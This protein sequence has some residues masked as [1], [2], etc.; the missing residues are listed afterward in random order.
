[1]ATYG[2]VCSHFSFLS[3][4]ISHYTQRTMKRH[5]HLDLIGWLHRIGLLPQRLTRR[6]ASEDLLKALYEAHSEGS[7]APTSLPNLGLSQGAT[8][9]LQTELRG[10]GYLCPNSL[11]LT[12][13]GK[14]RAIELTRAHRLYELYLAEHSGYSPEDWHRLAH[15]KEHELTEEEHERIAKLLGNPL[16]DPHGDPIPTSE[17]IRPDVPLALPLEELAPH[18]WYFVLHIEDDEPVSY[19]RLSAL[20]LTRDSIF[21]LEE[22]TPTSCTIRYEGETFTFPT[23]MLLAL[24]LR[25]ASEKEVTETH[26]DQVQRLTRLPLGTETKVLALS[27]ACRGAMR[28]RLMD[29][30]FVPGS[31]IS[32]DMHSPLGNPSAYIVRGAAIALR[33]DQARYILIQPPTL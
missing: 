33:E 32:V 23:S 7:P 31:S 1:M 2:S 13:E 5:R 8:E 24:T 28:R 12:P 14:R 17:G 10:A 27:P 3:K 18:T 6:T 22:L 15:T 20:G 19:Q 4:A 16:F 25:Q 29:L 9:E 30:G 11:E 26:A 21:A